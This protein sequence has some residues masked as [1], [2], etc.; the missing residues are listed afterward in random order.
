MG[1][2]PDA[3]KAA[4]DQAWRVFDLPAPDTTGVCRQCCMDPQI[5]AD[6]LEHPARELPPDYIRDWYSAA[7]DGSIRHAHVAWLLPRVM[8]MLAE[9]QVVAHVGNEAVFSRLPLTGFPDRW[10]DRQ[11]AAVQGFALA[12]FDAF[13]HGELPR[14][15]GGLDAALCMFGEGGL[16]IRPLLALLDG[17]PDATLVD[18]LDREWVFHGV[19][20]ICF[21]AFWSREPGRATAWTWY[22]GEG[23]RDRMELAAYAGNDKAFAVHDAIVQARADKPR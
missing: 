20:R 8:E 11:V 1:A 18:L 2:R 19:G 9:G 15:Q 17:L 13:L 16:D 6:F 5:E 12:W 10:P 7:Y 22:T 3:L 4:I 21:D 23:L 14:S